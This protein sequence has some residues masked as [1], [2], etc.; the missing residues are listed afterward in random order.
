[1]ITADDNLLA[2]LDEVD[3]AGWTVADVLV[4]AGY[5]AAVAVRAAGQSPVADGH[6]R[7]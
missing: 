1:M 6:R 5:A 2:G 3:W 4:P 7:K